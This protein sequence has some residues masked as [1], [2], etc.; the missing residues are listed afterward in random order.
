MKLFELE[1]KKIDFEGVNL[2][3]DLDFFMNNDALF[4]RK[5]LYPSIL[6]MK[7]KVKS[8]ASCKENH[9]MP[10]IEQG[11]NSYC[12]KFKL[13]KKKKDL[14][15][16]EEVRKLALK[17]FHREKDNIEKGVYDRSSK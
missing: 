13:D 3:D 12:K 7:D 14:F 10:C 5:V 16:D 17:M 6:S 8:G 15:A 1:D 4:Y 11:V 2:L 9:F